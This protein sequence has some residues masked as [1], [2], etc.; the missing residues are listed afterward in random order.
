MVWLMEKISSDAKGPRVLLHPL[1]VMVDSVT[2]WVTFD[3]RSCSWKRQ[4]TGRG[5]P[6][7]DRQSAHLKVRHEVLAERRSVLLDRVQESKILNEMTT[8]Q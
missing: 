6:K 3:T 8:S 7:N 4:R 5:R 2:S 1:A